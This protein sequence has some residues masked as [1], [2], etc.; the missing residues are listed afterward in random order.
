VSRFILETVK[1]KYG[2]DKIFNFKTP[3][4]IDVAFHL[5]WEKYNWIYNNTDSQNTFEKVV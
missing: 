4:K 3:H 5:T 2:H 1:K